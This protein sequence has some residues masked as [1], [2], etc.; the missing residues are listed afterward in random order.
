MYRKDSPEVRSCQK[1]DSAEIPYGVKKV[2]PSSQKE[3]SAEVPSWQKKILQKLK[4]RGVGV[5]S[6]QKKSSAEA[7]SFPIKVV[8]SSSLSEKN[9][10]WNHLLVRKKVV[11]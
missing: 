11:Q 9:I 10:V 1:I 5:T 7:P 2:V 3:G 6:C 4:K 8:Q